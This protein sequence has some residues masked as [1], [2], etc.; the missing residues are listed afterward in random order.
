MDENF[1]I[2]KLDSSK[3]VYPTNV[4]FIVKNKKT[5]CKFV[6]YRTL[7]S[8]EYFLLSIKDTKPFDD[9]KFYMSGLDGSV[10]LEPMNSK[11]E[12]EADYNLSDNKELQQDLKAC[13]I[14]LN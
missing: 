12:L 1:Y 7:K 6:L 4:G 13:G 5:I 11:Y 8:S 10:D 2:V 14:N 3:F 9:L